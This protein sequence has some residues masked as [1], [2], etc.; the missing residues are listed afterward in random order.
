MKI[1]TKGTTTCN[2][3]EFEFGD[4]IVFDGDIY[5]VVD[6]S[7]YWEELG[8]NDGMVHIVRLRDGFMDGIRVTCQV[9]RINLVAT[10]EE[11]S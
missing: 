3:G 4:T 9:S 2:A 8:E 6:T 10:V 5:M 11:E 7:V 1:K